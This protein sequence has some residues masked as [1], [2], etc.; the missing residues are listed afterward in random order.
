MKTQATKTQTI[1]TYWF[2]LTTN[3]EIREDNG[4]FV[5][6]R[7]YADNGE[8]AHEEGRFA[9]IAEAEAKVDEILHN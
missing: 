3:I 9:T 5:V 2:T 1:K 8:I 7:A 6:C 4:E